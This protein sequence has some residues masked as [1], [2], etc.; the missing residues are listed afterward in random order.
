MT[1]DVIAD[2][3]AAVAALDPVRSSL[4]AEL[5]EPSSAAG[6]AARTGIPRQKINYH[7]R[8]LEAHKLVRIADSRKWGGL[9]EHLFV[10]TASAYLVSPDAMGKAS[11]PDPASHPYDRLSVSYLIALA[12]RAVREASELWT[13]AVAQQKRLAT[14]S[15]DTE[16]AFANPADRADFTSELAAAVQTLAAKYHKPGETGA[17]PHRLILMSHPIPCQTTTTTTTATTASPS[18]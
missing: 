11:P 8:T 2:P 3:A 5:A 12:A 6:L 15:I 18:T 13:K 9:T 16:I 17:R 7:L 1:V 4:L 10:A 14:L